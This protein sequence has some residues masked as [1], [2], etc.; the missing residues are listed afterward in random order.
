[1]A[2]L[3]RV[4]LFKNFELIL[5]RRIFRIHILLLFA[6]FFLLLFLFLFFLSSLALDELE[7]DLDGFFRGRWRQSDS[8]STL[9]NF[10][11]LQ[12]GEF[13]DKESLEVFEDPSSELLVAEGGESNIAWD[14]Q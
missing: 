14:V 2:W 1:M 13:F 3:L 11:L 12:I 9:W 6:L 8:F 5:N 4:N 7:L 10:K